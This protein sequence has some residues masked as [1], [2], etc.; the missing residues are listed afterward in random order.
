MTA[1]T[2]KLLSEIVRDMAS[3]HKLLY[4]RKPISREEIQ[5]ITLSLVV[6]WN[7]EQTVNEKQRLL[8][9]SHRRLEAVLNATG[10]AM[11]MYDAAGQLVFANKGYEGLCGMTEGE[12]RNFPPEALAAR[13]EERLQEFQLPEMGKGFLYENQE[14]LVQEVDSDKVPTQRLFYR[15]IAQCAMIA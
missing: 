6:K 15:S 5:Q 7:L 2:D 4:I 13:F 12:L 3:L 11:V 8:A 1:Y 10:D 14:N 9:T